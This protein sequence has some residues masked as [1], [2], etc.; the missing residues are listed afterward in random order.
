MSG[1][2]SSDDPYDL[3]RFL[4]AQD[5]VYAQALAELQRGTKYSHWMW[6]VFPQLDGLALSST[7][8][9]YAIKSLDEARAYLAHPVLGARLQACAEAV[10]AVQGRSA[11]QIL[12]TPDDLKLRSCATLFSLVSAPGSV[13]EQVL[14]KYYGGGRDRLTLRLLGLDEPV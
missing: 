12:G 7:A 6:F 14:V 11:T 2:R 10:L 13:F 5:G 1:S 9:R 4:E 3:A 8:S